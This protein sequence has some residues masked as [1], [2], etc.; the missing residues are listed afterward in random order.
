MKITRFENIES[1]QLARELTQF[2]YKA[3]KSR[4]FSKDYGL[5][6]QICRASVSAMSNVA[7]GFNSGSSAEFARFL[8]YAQRSCSEV[9]SQL[10]VALDQGYI[11]EKQFSDIYDLAG[12]TG[13]KIGVFIKYLKQQRTKNYERKTKN[14]ELST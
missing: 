13:S 2:I 5:K 8:G 4:E 9:Q 1:W 12:K 14:D 11:S 6:D 3:V 10:Y 7:E